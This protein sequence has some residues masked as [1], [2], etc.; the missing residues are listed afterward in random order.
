MYTILLCLLSPILQ[1]RNIEPFKQ[2][3][4]HKFKTVICNNCNAPTLPKL[5]PPDIITRSGGKIRG[6]G[7]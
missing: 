7:L 4:Q 3:K 6:T 1:L 2:N 5:P